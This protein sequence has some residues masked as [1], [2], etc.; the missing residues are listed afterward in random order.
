MTTTALP[1]VE[2]PACRWRGDEV[3]PG[4]SECRSHKIVARRGVSAETCGRCYC[5]DH[6]PDEAA[7]LARQ[8]R[9]WPEPKPHQDI[10]PL[11]GGWVGS[12]KRKPWQY[13]VAVV[14]AHLETPDQLEVALG[15]LQC[16]TVRPYVVVVDTGST[17][18][19]VMT[20]LEPLRS[21][22]VELHYVRAHGYLHSSAPVTAALDLAHSLADRH[23]YLFHTH[24]DVF[25]RRRDMLEWFLAQCGPDCPVVG[26]QMSDRSWATD[27]WQ[28]CPSHTATCLFLPTVRRVRGLWSLSRYYEETGHPAGKYVGWPDTESGFGRILKEAGVPVKLL[29]PEPNFQLD[30]QEHFDHAR[31]YTG[32]VRLGGE[33]PLRQRVEAYMARALAEAKQRLAVWRKYPEA[34]VPKRGCRGAANA[35]A[36]GG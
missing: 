5:R 36:G 20:R 28:H 10:A 33:G 26:Y 35:A 2:A 3:A 31:S 27:E 15:L 4:L 22:N 13:R 1:L 16:Q 32:A 14:M 7:A 29:G 30:R 21:E 24:A 19:T 34:R 11:S 18:D 12:L 25:P 6:A 8:R 9:E 17:W 23:Q